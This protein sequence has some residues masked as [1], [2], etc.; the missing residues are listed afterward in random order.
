M[1][2]VLDMLRLLFGAVLG[3]TALDYFLPALVPLV[4]QAQWTDPMA[5]RVMTAFDRSGLLAVAKFI[6]LIAGVLLL[7]NRATPFALAAA[8]PVNVCGLY[9]A[10]FLEAA[11][12][13]AILA[14][15]T[16][17]LNGLLMLACLPY[18]RGVLEGG[19]LADGEGPEP[20]ANYQSLFVSPLANAPA[21]AYLPAVLV[22]AAAVAFY[23]FVVPFANGTTG[24]VTLALPT[25]LLVAGFA[26]SL[27]LTRKG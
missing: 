14:V 15:L 6:H 13:I 10:L 11:P 2:R 9:I 26:R 8:L 17:T 3:I 4:E 19:A 21:R 16:A 5:A 22:L 23:W 20:G 7:T 18:Y 1:T 27:R 12:L 24:L 25:V